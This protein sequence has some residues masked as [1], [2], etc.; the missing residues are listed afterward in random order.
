MELSAAEFV[1][2]TFVNEESVKC[3]GSVYSL[4]EKRLTYHDQQFWIYIGIYTALVLLAGLM[5]GLTMGL[6]SLDPTTLAVMC[7]GGSPKEQ[8]HAR[9][10]LPLVKRH[11]LLLVTLLLANAAAVEAMPIFLDRLSDPITA[12]V[13]S[14]TAVLL[15]GEVIPQAICTRFGLAIGAALTPLVYVLMGLLIVVAYP[16]AKFLDCLL[17]EDHG[18]FYRRA[19]LKVLV[20]LHGPANEESQE[21]SSR[22]GSVGNDDEHLTVDEV[23]IIKEHLAVDEVLI[24]KGALDMK[25]KT[26]STAMVPIASVYM[27]SVDSKLDHE[28]MTHII[29]RGHSRIPVYGG[30]RSNVI[31]LLLTKTLIKLNPADCIPVSKILESPTY[32]RPAMFIDDSM[33]LFDLLNQFQTG[34]SNDNNDV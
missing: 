9:R 11:H 13:V 4:P 19:Q 7:E 20:D 2:C 26:A 32:A 27:L 30:S 34:K 5:S 6:L 23:L 16:L 28:T 10:I 15:F 12:I 1:N 31:A 3:N 8:R 25:Y 33:P 21:H 24:I 17:G 29:T 18:T 14:V 22:P